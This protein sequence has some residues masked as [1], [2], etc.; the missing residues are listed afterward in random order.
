MRRWPL[1]LGAGGLI[2]AY[3]NAVQLQTG[4][5]E[6]GEPLV[7]KGK[8]RSLSEKIFFDKACRV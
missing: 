1:P 6:S 2:M 4:R 3:Y 5:E 7:A 8:I